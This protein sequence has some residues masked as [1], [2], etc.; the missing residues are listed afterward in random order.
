[1][2]RRMVSIHL[3][4]CAGNTRRN[5]AGSWYIAY[6]RGDLR[7]A[8]GTQYR[9]IETDNKVRVH[10]DVRGHEVWRGEVRDP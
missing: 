5:V 7:T 1:M 3:R 9:N 4:N 10:R 6:I 8:G 2:K